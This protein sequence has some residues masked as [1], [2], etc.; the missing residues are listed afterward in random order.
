M[1]ECPGQRDGSIIYYFSGHMYRK[2]RSTD[3]ATYYRCSTRRCFAR[4]IQKHRVGS[5]VE[6]S[7]HNHDPDTERNKLLRLRAAVQR[8]F[9]QEATPL[10]D[11]YLQEALRCVWQTLRTVSG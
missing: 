8:R 4:L 5:I 11:I 3:T 9:D 6:V 2:N 1:E 7:P 10:L